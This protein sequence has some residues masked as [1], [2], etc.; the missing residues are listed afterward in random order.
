MLSSSVIQ[1]IFQRATMSEMEKITNLIEKN[2]GETN[3]KLESLQSTLENDI[4][5]IRTDLGQHNDRITTIEQDIRAIQESSRFNEIEIQIEML[6]QDRLRNNIRL[7]GLPPI[8]FDNPTETVIAIDGILHLSLMP[9]DF[10][11]YADKHKSSLMISFANYSHKRS[12]MSSLQQRKSLLAEEVFPSIQSNANIFANDQLTPYFAKLFQAA[13]QAKKEG[14]IHSASSLGGR[15][16][17]KRNETSAAITIETHQ[18]LTDMLGENGHIEAPQQQLSGPSTSQNDN[19][20]NNNNKGNNNNN[21]DHNNRGKGPQP[22]S[23]NPSLQRYI[24]RRSSDRRDNRPTTNKFRSKNRE[25]LQRNRTDSR[26][27]YRGAIDHDTSPP[28]REPYYRS[29]HRSKSFGRS[30]SPSYRHRYSHRR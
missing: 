6:K 30:S 12:F 3:K 16:K 5:T 29:E 13:W 14:R 7:T 2:F 26:D 15:I 19:S 22:A 10:T 25:D 9:S 17:V 24:D 4:A 20:N 8:A 23:T 11:V 18:Q 27:R 1:I 21:K 28:S